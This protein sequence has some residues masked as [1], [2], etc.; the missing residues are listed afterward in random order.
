M[1]GYEI[2]GN[3]Y[4]GSLASRIPTEAMQFQGHPTLQVWQDWI[5]LSK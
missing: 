3:L 4:P 5:A 2:A 1:L